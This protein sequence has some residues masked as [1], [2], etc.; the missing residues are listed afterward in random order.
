MLRML[1]LFFIACCVV[2]NANS[3]RADEPH[4]IVTIYPAYGYQDQTR[5]VVPLRVWVHE[6]RPAA[7]A[8]AVEIVARMDGVA[9]EELHNFQN[10]S[11]RSGFVTLSTIV[12]RMQI[13]WT[14]CM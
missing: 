12:K 8:A 1:R 7:E 11:W 3:T 14:G 6:S 2:W 10:K 13:D 9:S 5:W 4:E